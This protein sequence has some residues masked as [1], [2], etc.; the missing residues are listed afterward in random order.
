MGNNI[1]YYLKILVNVH[2]QL[3]SLQLLCGYLL[4]Y[5][6]FFSDCLHVLQLLCGYLLH[7]ITFFSD[8]LCVLL[9][10]YLLIIY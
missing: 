7:Y 4:H 8:R 6:T 2:L 1:N 9:L 3:S 10:L 5:I